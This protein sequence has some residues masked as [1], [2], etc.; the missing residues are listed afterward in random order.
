MI[1]QKILKLNPLQEFRHRIYLPFFSLLGSIN[2]FIR[3]VSTEKVIELREVGIE[4]SVGSRSETISYGKL[5]SVLSFSR[6]EGFDR[7]CDI[8]CGLGRSFI[9]GK[10]SFKIKEIVWNHFGMYREMVYFYRFTPSS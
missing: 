1:L 3:G 7:L 10:E 8:G 6:S 2:D 4:T 5:K 9:V